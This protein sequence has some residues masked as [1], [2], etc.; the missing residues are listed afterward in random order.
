MATKL[1][2]KKPLSSWNTAY[3]YASLTRSVTAAVTSATSSVSSGT[4][5]QCTKTAGGT[6]VKWISPPFAA[7]ATVSGTVTFN[8]WAFEAAANNNCGIRME[9]VKWSAGVEG[10]VFA[11]AT[12]GA[13]TEL[14]T[15]DAVKNWT[16]APTSTNFAVGDR[17]VAYVYI[18]NVGTMGNG[19]VTMTYAGITA[20][21]T[22]DSYFQL[23]E[24]VTFQSEAENIE[25]N[26][27]SSSPNALNA[28]A[29]HSLIV[30]FLTWNNTTDTVSSLSDGTNTYV[31]IG[32]KITFTGNSLQM[33]YVAD[34]ASSPSGLTLTATLSGSAVIQD[35]ISAQYAGLNPAPLDANSSATGTGT[36]MD[37]GAMSTTAPSELIMGVGRAA[38]NT[39]S[40]GANFM[41]RLNTG[42][43]FI[44]EEWSVTA[45][46]VY[47]AIATIGASVAWGMISATFKWGSQPTVSQDDIEN[48][49]A[50]LFRIQLPEPVTSVFS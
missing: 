7:N 3:G 25:T 42:Q 21:V 2:L 6:A 15:S 32:S 37:A 5:I 40:L 43:I 31:S 12:F 48:P 28:V 30:V 8:L 33:F 16:V 1:F 23:N 34:S 4:K 45:Q 22:G 29:A 9:L 13:P 24:N 50:S 44:F 10:S 35:F 18:V 19:T 38:S 26:Y 46:A 14:T 27:Q 47:D 36:A 41:T 17:I 49:A 11:S 39:I 20:A